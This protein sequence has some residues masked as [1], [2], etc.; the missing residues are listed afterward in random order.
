LGRGAIPHRDGFPA[1]AGKVDA[2]KIPLLQRQ[3]RHTAF[4]QGG[5]AVIRFV[6]LNEATGICVYADGGGF[7]YGTERE[8]NARDDIDITLAG[9]IAEARVRKINLIAVLLS[10]GNEDWEHAQHCEERCGYNL[11]VAAGV[12]RALV[13]KHWQAIERVADGVLSS[14]TG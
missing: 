12:V 4:H 3:R 9:P 8:I 11:D 10:S 7:A 2:M 5:H 13:R 14:T 6:L 1:D